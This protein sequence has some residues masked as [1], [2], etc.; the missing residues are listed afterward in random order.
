MRQSVVQATL[1]V[2][3]GLSSVALAQT[4]LDLDRVLEV[5]SANLEVQLSQS[6][7][8]AARADITS[9]DRN[10]FPVLSARTSSIDLQNG[11]GGGNVWRDKRIDKGLGLDITQE[12]GEKREWRT[13]GAKSAARAAEEDVAQTRRRQLWLASMAY[14]EWLAQSERL[15]HVSAMAQASRQQAQVAAQRQQAGDVSMQDRLRFDIEARRAEAEV[16][17]AQ[18]AL[19][20]AMLALQLITRIESPTSI[21]SPAQSWPNIGTASYPAEHWPQR[22]QQAVD[23]RPDVAAAQNRLEAARHGL[24]LALAQKKS[25]ITWGSSFDHYPGTSARLLEFRMQMPLQWN[26]NYQG[27][28]ARAQALVVQSQDLLAQTRLQA[29]TELAGLYQSFVAA[30]GRWQ[31]H[32]EGILPQAQQV[33]AQA[34]LAYQKGGLSLTDLLDARRTFHQAW[35]DCLVARLEWTNAYSGLLFHTETEAQA[36]TQLTRSSHAAGFTH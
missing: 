32:Q 28:I 24:D 12:R 36:R 34:E 22:L 7:L 25:D 3:V 5:A 29:Q 26:Y 1:W 31:A 16:P 17:S 19:Q 11:I 13:R 18:A 9:A 21:W 8:A 6:A 20:R 35:L 2:G 4:P 15:R 14:F 23:Q 33:L 27:E 30:Q 10:P